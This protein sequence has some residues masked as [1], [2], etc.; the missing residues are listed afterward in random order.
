MFL[1]IFLF[2]EIEIEI[3]VF[4]V[5]FLLVSCKNFGNEYYY[6]KEKFRGEFLFVVCFV[7]YW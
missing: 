2:G 4:F 5:E 1:F 7:R 3:L 6:V